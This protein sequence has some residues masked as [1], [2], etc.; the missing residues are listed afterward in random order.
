MAT[1]LKKKF[2]HEFNDYLAIAVGLALYALSWT[3]LMLPYGI[4]TGGVTGVA[5]IIFYATGFEMQI[6]YLLINSVFLIFALKIL[7]W[8]FCAKTVY[9]VL[10]LTIFLKVGQVFMSDGNGG[11]KLILGEGQN[12]MAC[13]V[14]A[15]LCGIGVGMCFAANGSTGGT[16]IIAAIV[17]KYRDVSLGRVILFIDILIIG[18]TYF[19]FHDITRMMFGY[20]TM[21]IMSASLDFYVNSARQSIQIL[22]F[23][24]K[25]EELANYINQE[26]HRGVTVLNGMGWYSKKESHV[27]VVLVRKPDA[28]NLLRAIKQIDPNAFI[29]MSRVVGVY[30]QGFDK[31]KVK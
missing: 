20:V 6:S 28:T 9:A 24:Y 12:F 18:S 4:T 30:G 25:Y 3:T 29:S 14:G 10:L 23:S 2:I 22:I 21:M 19:V 8:R 17:N 13:V 11:F 1:E 15:I 31:I 7:G 16:D 27:L 5:A 26:I